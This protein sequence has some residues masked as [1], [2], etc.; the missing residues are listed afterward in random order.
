LIH[1]EGGLEVQE[2]PDE[3]HYCADF[4]RKGFHIYLSCMSSNECGPKLEIG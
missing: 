3:I 4:C 1:A 2:P